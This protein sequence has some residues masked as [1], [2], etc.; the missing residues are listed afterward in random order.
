M[1]Y[2]SIKD[3]VDTME[4]DDIKKELKKLDISFHHNHGVE[5]LAK[6]LFDSTKGSGNQK[7]SDDSWAKLA[8]DIRKD[9]AKVKRDKGSKSK[10][11]IA[12]NFNYYLGCTAVNSNN[13]KVRY[14]VGYDTL[15][16]GEQNEIGDV[17]ELD[18]IFFKGSTSGKVFENSNGFKGRSI[19]QTKNELLQKFLED[20]KKFN[21]DYAIY[22]P[23]ELEA[24]KQEEMIKRSRLIVAAQDAS[25]D[26]LICTLS[27]LEMK[28]G[29]A[30]SFKQMYGSMTKPKLF[31]RAMKYIDS[32]ADLFLDAMQSKASKAVFMVNVARAMNRIEVTNDGREV[33]WADNKKTICN[34]SLATDWQND[35]LDFMFSPEGKPLFEKLQVMT[36]V[37]V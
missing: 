26:D 16:I 3:I 6:L 9:V 8:D 21:Q 22:D 10:T 18:S 37:F 19:L 31:S 17:F 25:E 4:V 11:Y 14:V 27:Y 1:V 24:R 13:K 2:A 33:R 30:N 34:S 36:G 32:D 12:K 29:N 20:N 15:D 35:L 28:K 23:S 5:K 7:P